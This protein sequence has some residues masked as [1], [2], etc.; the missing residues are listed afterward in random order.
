[1]LAASFPAASAQLRVWAEEAAVSR[2]Y[3]GIHFRSDNEAGLALG[4]R[5]AAVALAQA[6][7]R[8]EGLAKRSS[9][10][11][12]APWCEARTQGAFISMAI[13]ARLRTGLR[14]AERGPDSTGPFR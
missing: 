7:R 3:A 10:A 1:V 14:A 8:Q 4:R 12:C 13:R 11:G 2:L 9:L 6:K 5:I